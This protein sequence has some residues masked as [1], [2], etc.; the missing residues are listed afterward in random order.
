[1]LIIVILES[2][3]SILIMKKIV[4]LLFILT[5]TLTFSGLMS[6]NTIIEELAILDSSVNPF[7]YGRQ[8]LVADHMGNYH[9][10]YI[11]HPDTDFL[12]IKRMSSDNGNSWGSPETISVFTPSSGSYRFTALAPSVTIDEAG[13]F[14]ILY[15]YRGLPLYNSSYA[16]YP[17]SHIN[18][19][20]WVDDQW[21]TEVDV[22]NDHEIQS[23]QGNAST[24]CYLFDNQIANYH[25]KQYYLGLDYAWWATKYNI[26]YSDNVMGTWQPGSPL[27]TF[28]LG[29]YDIR[30]LNA[31]SIVANNDSLYAIWY[32]SHDCVVEMKS[33]GGDNWSET[34]TIFND[35]YIPETAIN[36]Y[37]MSVGSYSNGSESRITMF[38]VPETDFNELLILRKS[39]NMPWITDTLMLDNTYG[40][41][42]PAMVGDTTILFMMNSGVENLSYIMKYLPGQGDI[43]TSQLITSDMEEHFNNLV[44][45]DKTVN[46]VAY[47]VLD[48]ATS[49]YYLK[50][51]RVSNILGLEE[52]VAHSKGVVLLQ[53]YPNPF[54]NTTTISY[55]I[56]AA[57][58]VKLTVHNGL[59]KLVKTLVDDV[60]APG[61]YTITLD[62]TD[63]ADGVY[64]YQ[65]S[66][67]GHA[68]TR[69]MIRMR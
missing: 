43:S 68:Q 37:A 36:P 69:K 24:V 18:Y 23:G 5:A 51:G 9:L 21:V 15:E 27:Y 7:Y 54:S 2:N 42:S 17:P 41:I 35:Y 26:V 64:Y 62:A 4:R 30:I 29:N 32:Q 49:T 59:G 50:I 34:S 8:S 13:N 45:S 55:S 63:F 25:G 16:E 1:V 48:A 57:T 46:P 22:V 31:S 20:H 67:D 52:P 14:H 66:A 38:R 6:Q 39:V 28:D 47:S 44:T 33:Y 11:S 65:I 10:F 60:K 3:Q 40:S 61:N 19:V 12:L 58:R 53:N 56:A